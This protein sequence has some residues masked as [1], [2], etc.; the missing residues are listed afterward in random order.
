[1]SLTVA[2]DVY[3]T[4][5]DTQGG[6]ASLQSMIGDQA[7]RFSLTWREKQLEYSFRRGLMKQY[8]DFGICTQQALNFTCQYHK[9]SLS[10]LQKNTLLEGYKTLPA[11][12]DVSDSLAQLSDSKIKLYAFSNGS[13]AAVEG[14]LV[15]AGIQAYF[16]DVVSCDDIKSF[17]PDP[18]VYQHF[19]KQ[20]NTSLGEA[21]LVSSNPFDVVGARSAGMRAAWVQRSPDTVFDPWG[22]EPTIR[23]HSLR[24]LHEHLS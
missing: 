4:L 17:K 12:E 23:I 22:I 6:L 18:A 15:H 9:I 16:D 24:E 14:L 11:F 5:I 2:F 1:M 19:L 20:S 10:E 21:W 7:D 3:G 13:K 8:A